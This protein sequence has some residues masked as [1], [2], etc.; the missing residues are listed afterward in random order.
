MRLTHT[1]LPIAILAMLIIPAFV[2]AEG[3]S[4]F[5]ARAQL[6][7]EGALGVSEDFIYDFGNEQHH[8][9]IREIPSVAHDGKLMTVDGIRAMRQDSSPVLFSAEQGGNVTDVRIGDPS[10]FV[11]GEQYYKLQYSVK[12]GARKNSFTWIAFPTSKEKIDKFRAELYLPQPSNDATADCTLYFSTGATNTC[13]IIPL[14]AGDSSLTR[15]YRA[16]LINVESAS[17]VITL[18]YPNGFIDTPPFWSILTPKGVIIVTTA[19]VTLITTVLAFIIWTLRIR[20]LAAW[21]KFRKGKMKA[22]HFSFLSR[23]IFL[24]GV[25]DDAAVVATVADLADRGYLALDPKPLPAGLGEFI[26]YSIAAAADEE[27]AGAE[28]VLYGCVMNGIPSLADW[29]RVEFPKVK[30]SLS[31]AAKADLGDHVLKD[32]D[33]EFLTLAGFRADLV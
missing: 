17:V 1:H 14:K 12:G 30:N 16:D 3:F 32:A 25:V 10:Q 22:E 31:E 5:Q 13:P 29:L 28:G 18:H 7:K 21:K 8:G 33:K 19:L 4:A 24:H 6:S 11:T 27:P 23:S 20:I 26:D 15:A 2:H 9:V